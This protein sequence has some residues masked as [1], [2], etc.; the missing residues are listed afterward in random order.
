MFGGGIYNYH[1]DSTVTH[2]FIW[3]NSAGNGGGIYNS[4]ANVVVTDSE[5]YRNYASM[6]GGG[7]A[8]TNDS[9]ATIMNSFFD[10]NAAEY[11]GGME[12]ADSKPLI[13]GCTFVDNQANYGAGIRN[14]YHADA[15]IT[16]CMFKRNTSYHNG[17]GI[18]NEDYSA[19]IITNCTFE[20]NRAYENGGG[21]HNEDH[22]TPHISH[23][24]I[25][26]NVALESGGGICTMSDAST[27]VESCVFDKN[28][29]LVS[30][31]AVYTRD[32]DCTVTNCIFASNIVLE[33]GAGMFNYNSNSTIP[34]S[35]IVTNCT[36]YDNKMI[37]E[38]PEPATE[39]GNALYS[40]WI[41]TVVTNCILWDG[42]E[43]EILS[44]SCTPVV[45]YCNVQGGYEGTGIIDADPL[46]ANSG[47]E[48]F[49]L[50]IGSPCINTG[51]DASAASYGSVT[52]DITGI[53]RPQNGQYDMGAYERR[54]SYSPASMQPLVMT[55]LGKATQS[56]NAIL[57]SLPD[58]L[59][60]EQQS[61]L[62]EIQAF[63]EQAKTLGNPI[64]ANGAL[65]RALAQMDALMAT[66]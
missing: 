15:T 57:G 26:G 46:F 52:D 4:H 30:G 20:G 19:P 18:C 48:D 2:C 47:A 38:D 50:A 17:G 7:M 11:G 60:G 32:A 33:H 3:S 64:A 51:T 9:N 16:D 29:A 37:I 62:D 58:T 43:S 6:Y 56:W 42:G 45:T 28:G 13:D 21:I 31:G 63:M 36:F 24:T 5:L 49:T 39:E 54:Q 34:R 8:N 35:I 61:L 25:E 12:N 55:G 27:T 59:S 14:R 40:V 1:T 22:S 44:F 66:V 65:Q 41:D 53:F 10:T 23:C